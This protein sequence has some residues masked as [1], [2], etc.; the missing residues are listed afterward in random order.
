LTG[1]TGGADVFKWD[2]NDQLGS[3]AVGDKIMDFN[4]TEGDVLNLADL[5]TGEHSTAGGT[6]NLDS[7]LSFAKVGSDTVLTIADVN[8]GAAGVEAQ[9][10]TFVNTDLF[11]QTGVALND[12][13]ALVQNLLDNGNLQTDG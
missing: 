4:V 1:G 3:T 12:S 9:T 13:V 6:Y 2:L 5:L 11:V 7:Y 8:G 10:V